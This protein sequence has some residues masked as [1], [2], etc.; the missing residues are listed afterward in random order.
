LRL[1]HFLAATVL[2]CPLSA[3]TS[4]MIDLRT[5]PSRNSFYVV[6]ASRGGSATGHAFVVWGM[7]DARR[8]RT[9]VRARGLYPD[10]NGK[11]CSSLVRNVPGG[12]LDELQTHSFQSIDQELI[13]RVD[14]AVYQRSWQVAL[15]WDCRHEF[16]LVSRDCVE[17]LKAV[18]L[19]LGIDM[20]QRTILRSTPQAYV[21]ALVA[22]NAELQM[23]T[24]QRR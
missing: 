23:A 19:S 12:L 1:A 5:E 14:E 22:E 18:G 11:N 9:T 21:R 3:Q 13:V 2:I 20:P 7:E 10:G 4:K 17:F 15:Q 8:H 24:D 6:L 16:S